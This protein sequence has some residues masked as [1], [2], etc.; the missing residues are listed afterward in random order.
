[1][2]TVKT[3]SLKGFPKLLNS[4]DW[5]LKILWAIGLVLLLAICMYQVETITSEYFSYPTIT[6]I[7]EEQVDLLRNDGVRIPDVLLCNLNPHGSDPSDTSGIPTVS[8][9]IEAVENL[10]KCDF[11]NPCT[12]V[13][14]ELLTVLGD[15]LMARE[16]Y[17]QYIGQEAAQKIGVRLETFIAECKVMVYTG[18][19][20]IEVDCDGIITFELHPHVSFYQCI[21]VHFPKQVKERVI[22]GI[23]LTLYLDNFIDPFKAR[24]FFKTIK[25]TQQGSG[26]YVVLYEPSTFPIFLSE[27][28]F[29]TAGMGTQMNYGIKT[30]SR[31]GEPYGNCTRYCD[32][33]HPK[34]RGKNVN[35]TS[36][37]CRAQCIGEQIMEQCGCIEVGTSHNIFLDKEYPEFPYCYSAKLNRTQILR[38]IQCIRMVLPPMAHSCYE[39]CAIPCDEIGYMT[40]ISTVQW[41]R[42]TL[43]HT[44]YEKVIE[45]KPYAWRFSAMKKDC[46][47]YS[48][49]T[50][51]QLQIQKLL[52]ENNFAKLNIFLSENTQLNIADQRKV[53]F[54][55]FLAQLGGALNLWNGITVVIVIE[56]LEYVLKL[57]IYKKE[58]KRETELEV[59]A[60]AELI[61][62]ELF[63][64]SL[65]CQ[66][67]GSPPAVQ[68]Q[69]SS[70]VQS[71]SSDA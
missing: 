6:T 65:F 32:A 62:R 51:E 57:C 5:S 42:P 7:R 61:R 19:S 63:I 29:A 49:C 37:V 16:G 39:K 9:F 11:D 48:N 2:E 58:K 59:Q 34:I 69:L 44:L 15:H 20:T 10:T 33:D 50:F 68:R 55:S 35:Y 28:F 52:V 46:T 30:V 21:E 66:Q 23:S 40:K 1:M 43:Y 56:A 36:D 12:P 25:I 67:F 53:T 38:N 26:V 41:P 54:F 4:T 47:E 60:K 3:T 13:E 45:D 71:D 64:S 14:K 8:E 27:S 31:L 70:K 22:V 18:S 17:F 24:E